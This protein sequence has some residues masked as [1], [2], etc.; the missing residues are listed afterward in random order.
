MLHRTTFFFFFFCSSGDWAQD[1]TLARQ[2]I[3][4][5]SHSAIPNQYFKLPVKIFLARCW[6]LTPVILGTQEAALRRIIVQGQPRQI[7]HNALSWKYPTH[8]HTHTQR[9]GRVAQVVVCL[10]KKKTFLT[11]FLII[12]EIPKRISLFHNS[13]SPFIV[14][15][16][17]HYI[18]CQ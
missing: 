10:P 3:Y 16:D 1:L 18:A 4:H 15:N 6:W 13:T 14:L 9:A 11:S 8:T 2:E 5:L 17:I 7:V 12:S